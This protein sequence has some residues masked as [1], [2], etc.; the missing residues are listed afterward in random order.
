MGAKKTL[1]EG[2]HQLERST[3]D[4]FILDLEN[5]KR[6]QEKPDFWVP[7]PLFLGKV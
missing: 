2:I 3:H 5:I 4:D 6:N 1:I 7:N